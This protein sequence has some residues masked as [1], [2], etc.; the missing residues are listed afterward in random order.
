MTAGETHSIRL[1][2]A[3]SGKRV[4]GPLPGPGISARG[5]LPISFSPG[6]EWFA[7]ESSRTRDQPGI[8]RG[9]RDD[10]RLAGWPANPESCL[11]RQLQSG[12]QAHCRGQ[13][14]RHRLFLGYQN[15]D[16][17]WQTT[18]SSREVGSVRFAPNGKWIVT[19]T[20]VP[21]P[22]RAKG[23]A[24]CMSGTWKR[25]SRSSDR[26][27]IGA[28][29]RAEA[30]FSPAGDWML[31]VTKDPRSSELDAQVRETA[32]GNPLGKPMRQND[33]DV[34]CFSPD[35]KRIVIVGHEGPEGIV[36]V[37]DPVT[38]DPVTPPLRHGNDVTRACF[39][40]DGRLLLTASEDWNGPP[41]GRCR[42]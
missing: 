27:T 21:D 34:A 1:W 8:T 35:G 30:A 36:R 14:R 23:T 31:G 19:N 4:A 28:S 42:R 12:W 40:P 22:D 25:P 13:S 26:S 24:R 39:S 16:D 41:V 29:S 6:R 9:L 32:T 20:L 10:H 38:G 2:D 5:A 17:G 7:V 11:G 33:L 37:W 18:A 15:G 3:V